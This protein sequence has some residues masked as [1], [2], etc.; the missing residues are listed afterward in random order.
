MLALQSL[1][2][3]LLGECAYPSLLLKIQ[4]LPQVY[5]DKMALYYYDKEAITVRLEFL[6]LLLFDSFVQE[7]FSEVSQLL[8]NRRQH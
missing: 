6:L 2:I 1:S 8:L 3:A 5:G 7:G 4:L